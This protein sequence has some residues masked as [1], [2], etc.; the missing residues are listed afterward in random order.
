MPYVT[1][2]IIMAKI[3]LYNFKYKKK[4]DLSVNDD[5]FAVKPKNDVVLQTIRY[6]LTNQQTGLAHTKTRGEVRGG[7]R[8]PW[9]QKGTGRARHGSIRSPLWVG[10]GVVFGP[11]RR[12]IELK[13]TKKMRQEAIKSA[14]SLK[15]NEGKLW[16][17]EGLEISEPKTKSVAIL[18]KQLPKYI[19]LL[20]ISNNKNDLLKLA[21]RNIKNVEFLETVIPS[22]LDLFSYDLILLDKETISK[23]ETLYIK[24][25][26]K[27]VI[28]EDKKEPLKA[29]KKMPVKKALKK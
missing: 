7:G 28:Q 27:P 14:L 18:L 26:A 29:T 6:H 4:Q 10:G 21:F 23:I 22:V 25:T 12:N 16:A 17:Y 8:K 11:R 1:S 13:I 24:P 2:L 15:L 3:I 5:I 20:I 9:R 19:K